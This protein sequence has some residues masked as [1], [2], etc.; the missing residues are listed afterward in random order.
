MLT[1][2]QTNKVFIAKGLS[3]VPYSSTAYS[4]VTS[5]YNRNVAC[6]ELPYSESPF[7]IWARDYM[8]VQVNKDKFVR[9]NYNPDYLRNY[10]QYKPDTSMILFNLGIQVIISDLVIDG[11]NIISCGDKVIMTDKI[12]LENAHIN[13]TTLIGKHPIKCIL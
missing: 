5:L 12:F 10:P 11:G 9:F 3:S 1:N 8:P 4:L 13:H 6:G 2:F 7:H